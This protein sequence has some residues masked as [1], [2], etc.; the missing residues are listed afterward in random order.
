MAQLK[1]IQ[2]RLSWLLVGVSLAWG[3]SI[4]ATIWLVGRS[5]VDKMLD[6]TL[7]EAAEILYGLLNFEIAQLPL[8]GAPAMSS[9]YVHDERLVWQVIGPDGAVRLQSHRAP[10][11]P[12]TPTVRL[13]FFDVGAQVKVAGAAH[14]ATAA[15]AGSA[16]SP[17]Y[18][19]FGM[20]LRD[21]RQTLYV[22]HFGV[23]RQDANLLA[24][25]AAAG[26]VLLSGM[27]GAFWLRSRVGKELNPLKE[28][29]E[30]VALYDPLQSGAKLVAPGRAE[31]LPLREAVHDFGTRLARRVAN[32][33]AFTAHA[34][35]ALR[36]PLA[37][38]DAQLAAALRECAPEQ[39]A[40]LERTREAARRLHS[41]VEALLT[42]FR[43]GVDLRLQTVDVG[44]LVYHLPID[45]IE[46][47]VASRAV[48]SADLNLLAA[49][50]LNLLDNAIR[51]GATMVQVDVRSDGD[52]TRIVLQDDGP[53]IPAAKARIIQDALDAQDYAHHMGLGLMLADLIARAHGGRLTLLKTEGG[54]TAEISLRAA[55][56]AGST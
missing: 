42:L 14:A 8:Q 45:G 53:G 26:A 15:S 11:H 54:V 35:H 31:L 16:D 32:E 41:V 7:L 9:P 3:L 56:V 24:I 13:G 17:E 22:A 28:L 47:R 1:S 52:M 37:G 36:T 43:S 38:M 4:S 19:V 6:Y 20:P 44:E 55:R 50:L 34:A 46:L 40:R 39:Q 49:G 10:A 25:Q 51:H 23:D 21:E 12:L 18:R 5:Q 33:R 30:S 29:S 2:R 48:I 27:V